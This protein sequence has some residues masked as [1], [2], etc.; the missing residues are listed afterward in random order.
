METF[1]DIIDTLGGSAAVARG[2]G[3]LPG[4]VRQMRRRGRIPPEYWPSLVDF[5]ASRGV[6]NVTLIVL[7]D[8]AARKRPEVVR[9][10]REQGR[11]A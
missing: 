9:D 7:A 8:L 1:A 5:A 3:L 4:T 6:V 2:I 11:A 10:L